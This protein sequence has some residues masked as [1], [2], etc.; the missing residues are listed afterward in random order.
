MCALWP[1]QLPIIHEVYTPAEAN[2]EQAQTLI[3]AAD[4]HSAQGVFLENDLF[5]SPPTLKAARKL[6]AR[7]EAIRSFETFYGYDSN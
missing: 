6:M 7:V 1:R 5:V 4:G 3:D 2:I